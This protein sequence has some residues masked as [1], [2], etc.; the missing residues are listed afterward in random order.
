MR[1][2][3]INSPPPPRKNTPPRSQ[4]T[5][6][7]RTQA[8]HTHTT[9]TH[10][11]SHPTPPPPTHTHTQALSGAARATIDACRT[12]FVWLVSLWLGWE[13]FLPLQVVGFAVL[14]SGERQEGRV[15]AFMWV[16]MRWVVDTSPNWAGREGE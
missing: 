4:P 2:S 16:C 14:F 8:T 13:R 15:G 10:S 12:L 6:T 11:L 3:P 5:S 9:H 1:S 7:I